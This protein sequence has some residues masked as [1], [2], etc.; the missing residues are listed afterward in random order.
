MFDT[1]ALK[2]DFSEAATRYDD[3]AQLQRQVRERCITLARG[4]WRDSAHILDAGC[5]TGQLASDIREKLLNW[6]ITGLDLASGMCKLAKGREQGMV[7]ANAEA[8][9]FAD[10]SFDGVFSSL[11][12]QWANDPLAGLREMARVTRPGGHI[13]ISTLTEGTLQELRTAFA[14]VDEEVHVSRFFN[15]NALRQLGWQSGCTLAFEEEATL[16]EHYPDAASLMHSLKAIGA[17]HKD[18]ARQ[19]GLMTPSRL[20]QIEHA[21]RRNFAT[22]RGLPATWRVYYM[23]LEKN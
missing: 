14:T 2:V 1:Q 13:I 11:M 4:L 15:K 22:V 12:L 9:P 8:M 19:K 10:A 16:V 6:R 3:S 5:G 18:N 7:N 21:Y 17:T 23:I 20:S